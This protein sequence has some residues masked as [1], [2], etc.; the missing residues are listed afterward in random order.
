MWSIGLRCGKTW[1]VELIDAELGEAL[2]YFGAGTSLQSQ[3]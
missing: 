1:E 2:K 3:L